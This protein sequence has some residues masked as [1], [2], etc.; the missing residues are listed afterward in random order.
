MG[1]TPLLPEAFKKIHVK[2][3]ENEL[4]SDVWMDERTERTFV[5]FIFTI[6]RVYHQYVNENLDSSVQKIFV[7]S[8][9]D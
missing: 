3:K 7:Q 1:R 6:Q 2:K 4:N 5:S 9:F 8:N